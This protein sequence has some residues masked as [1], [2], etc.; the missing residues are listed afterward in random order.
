MPEELLETLKGPDVSRA[1]FGGVLEY[2]GAGH[3]PG[4]ELLNLVFGT[5]ADDLLPESDEINLRRRAHDFAR[6][7][8]WSEEL[9]ALHPLKGEVLY[10]KFSEE[11]LRKLLECLQLE[12]PS[13][14]KRPNWE[15]AHFFPYTKSLVH[16]DARERSKRISLERRYFRGGGAHAY[17][18]L[19]KDPD[20]ARLERTRSGFRSLYEAT[21]TG[22]LEQ[23]ASVLA[24]QGYSDPEDRSDE[25]ES[26]GFVFNDDL[27]E[28]Y[29]RGTKRILEHTD[30]ASVVRIRSLIRW[31]AFWLVLIQHVRAARTLGEVNSHL[32]TDCASSFP[33]LRR[34]SQ[35]CLK[36][37]LAQIDETVE[38]T[39]RGLNGKIPDSRRTSIRGFF[40]ASA[41][42]IGLLNSWRGRRHFTLGIKMI[43]TLV[44]ASTAP[45]SEI[46]FE[47][48]LHEHL[49]GAYRLI[50]GRSSAEEA[51][52]LTS[53]DGSVFED[54]EEHLA[55]QMAAAGFLTEYSDATRM[56]GI[57][58]AT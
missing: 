54:N 55:R 26:Q 8:V 29:R 57:G 36:E 58:G 37:K 49:F 51:G 13:S 25:I 19:R 35:R 50:V 34:A 42:T 14:K 7:L 12:I 11:A 33:Q 45:Q 3:Y 9:F 6:K 44:M 4:V 53:I 46:T 16:W 27:D 2:D 56:V 24:T 10:D 30:L 48:F 39:A 21:E 23:L 40:W 22:A 47:K 52:L 18:V 20:K 41:A 15:R 1:I 28:I 17:R 43:E 38:N 31:T 32:I 5:V